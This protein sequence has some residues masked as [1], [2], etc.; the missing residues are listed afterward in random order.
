MVDI[1]VIEDEAL[2]RELT[3]DLLRSAGYTVALASN[4]RDGLNL[5]DQH[6]PHLVLCDITMPYFDGFDVLKA[7]RSNPATATKLFI[8]LTANSNRASL[9]QGMEMGADDYITKP[10]SPEDL[11]TAI[12]AQFAKREILTRQHETRLNQLRHNIDY[13]L[14]HELRTPLAVIIGNA[15][16]LLEYQDSFSKEEIQNMAMAMFQHS[17]RLNH[18][19]ENYLVYAQIELIA[20]DPH[21]RQ[22]VQNNI[23]RDAGPV[24]TETA[25]QI[26]DRYARPDDLVLETGKMAIP[27]GEESFRRIVEALVDNAFKFSPKGTPVHVRGWRENGAFHLQVT[28]RGRGMTAEQI[29]EIGAYMQ[30]DRMIHEQQGL[31]L[32]LAIA[33]RLA[34]LHGATFA[35]ESAPEK[36]TRIT[37]SFDI[38][39]G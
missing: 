7:V 3:G 32:G 39:A 14:P 11:I 24:I 36:G 28:D 10:F 34:E 5:I 22:L 29:A 20:S 27:I 33:R 12:N 26:A 13:A 15:E 1:V 4:G 16:M 19:F 18:V 35:L 31:G 6:D 38:Q 2:L 23:L 30:F 8:F 25:Q 21:K 37:V 9:R 17:Q